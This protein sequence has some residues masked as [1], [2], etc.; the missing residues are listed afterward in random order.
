[1]LKWALK[2]I[3]KQI[4]KSSLDQK[5]LKEEKPDIFEGYT[6]QSSYGYTLTL[7]SGSTITYE[8]GSDM[9][10]MYTAE[11]LAIAAANYVPPI[12]VPDPADM[13]TLTL[14]AGLVT[15][16]SAALEGVA[17]QRIVLPAG[18]R[19]IESRAF[20]ACPNLVYINLPAEIETIAA[21]AFADCAAERIF[22]ECAGDTAENGIFATETKLYAIP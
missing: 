20:A 5:R 12:E 16:E 21:D 19:R 15:L 17:A 7:P 22:V 2:V 11:E 1:M 13:T 4:F 9:K 18:L 3:I 14:P 8:F 6:T 10:K